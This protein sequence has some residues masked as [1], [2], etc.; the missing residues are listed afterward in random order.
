MP[1]YMNLHLCVRKYIYIYVYVLYLQVQACN[2][3]S[4][5]DEDVLRLS[6]LLFSHIHPHTHIRNLHIFFSCPFFLS[7][8]LALL[9]LLLVFLD[10]FFLQFAITY[11]TIPSYVFRIIFLFL[12]NS[13]LL[14]G[15][16][17]NLIDSVQLFTNG[18]DISCAHPW[19][20]II[21]CLPVFLFIRAKVI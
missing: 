10:N 14:C 5:L 2:T 6:L 19:V 7:S 11:I 16:K 17:Q 1:L 12:S 13:S 15:H 8:L 4:S 3:K 21:F 18:I 9:T 20:S